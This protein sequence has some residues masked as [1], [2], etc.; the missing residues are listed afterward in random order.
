MDADEVSDQYTP[1]DVERAVETYWDDH[2]AYEA[3]TE[4]HADDPA[5]FFVDG[6]PYTSGQMHLGT[7]WNKTLKDAVIRR[8]RMEGY[9][10]TDRPG[11]DM[12]GLPIEVK[13]EEE[14]GFDS[15]KDIEEYGMEAF[16]EECKSFAERNREK[17]DED[18]ESIGAWMDWDRPYKTI[19]PE[20]MESA[21]WAFPKFTRTASSSAASAR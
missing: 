21:W 18:F 11:Y 15:K 6:P 13:V 2:D 3:A 5:F 19:S 7:A 9:D 10:V 14:L 4:A 12:H 20:Y 17:M 8:K 1:A 16:I